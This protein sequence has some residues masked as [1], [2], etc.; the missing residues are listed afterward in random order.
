[1]DAAAATSRVSGDPGAGL[2][3]ALL[4]S[5][6]VAIAKAAT[7]A[8]LSSGG[9]AFSTRTASFI[10]QAHFPP[11][12]DFTPGGPLFGVQFSS[13]PCGDFKRPGSPLGLAGD[14]GG[15]PLYREGHVVGGLGIE[16][17]GVYGVDADPAELDAPPEESVALAGAAGFEAPDLIR[18]S[19]I[20]RRHPARVHDAAAPAAR[21]RRRHLAGPPRPAQP[22]PRRGDGGG[23]PRA[24]RP[25]LPR[26]CRRHPHGG[27]RRGAPRPGRAPGERDARGDPPAARLERARVDRGRGRERRRAR[28]LPERRRTE[29]RHR[30]LRAEGPQRGLLQ[31][32]RCGR[33]GSRGLAAYV[34]ADLL[35]DGRS[36]YTSRRWASWPAALPPGSRRGPGPFSVPIEVWSPFNTGLQLD[37][38]NLAGALSCSA[39]PG[40][41][42]GI[43]IFPG[44]IPLW[45]DGRLAG[46]IGVSGDGV[47]QDDLIAAAGSAGFEIPPER[48]SGTL[49]VQGAPALG[50]VPK[51]PG[52][53]GWRC[54]DPPSAR[55]PHAP[56]AAPR[57]R[58]AGPDSPTTSSC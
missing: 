54:A 39:V 17:D 27:R 12:V 57:S 7:G 42:N 24:R 25:A 22:R 32:A 16:G 1:M 53:S 40:L 43:T 41:P 46:A 45:K 56:G 4:P 29:L 15:L 3:G 48:R 52:A 51:A 20:R 35:L 49:E 9:N 34:P 10:V 33:G 58:S 13:L 28:L 50:Q 36:A 2:Q 55:S 38:V 18:A 8:L 31:R 23:D 44:G 26:A 14:P 21:R 37:L 5:D 6:R 30:R 19:Q 11:G 47:D